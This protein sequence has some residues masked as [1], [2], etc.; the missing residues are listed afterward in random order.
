MSRN[1]FPLFGALTLLLCPAIIIPICDPSVTIPQ[2][3]RLAILL[4]AAEMVG[5]GLV[6]RRK[7]AA[8]Y[9]SGILFVFGIRS[10]WISI[11]EVAFPL[12]LIVMLFGFSFTA[13]LVLT[14]R[15]WKHLASG[16]RYF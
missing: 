8:I 5:F 14:I 16:R 10:I 2:L 11:Y 12:N 6:S 1:Y 9:F 15:E 3:L 13:P 7:W 4:G